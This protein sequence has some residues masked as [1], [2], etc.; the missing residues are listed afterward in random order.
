MEFFLRGYGLPSHL[1]LGIED[2]CHM[3]DMRNKIVKEWAKQNQIEE[4]NLC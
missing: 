3:L 4:F 1:T 2:W